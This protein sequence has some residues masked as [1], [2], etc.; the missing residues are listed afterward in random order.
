[1]P[2]TLL[3]NE[4]DKVRLAQGDLK[5]IVKKEGGIFENLTK[6]EK[7]R[8]KIFVES[9]RIR[10][11]LGALTIMTLI[12]FCLVVP[13][14]SI[15]PG[16][17]VNHYSQQAVDAALE[18]GVSDIEAWTASNFTGQVCEPCLPALGDPN[19]K[20]CITNKKCS[21]CKSDTHIVNQADGRDDIFA[22]YSCSTRFA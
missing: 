17:P 7:I 6:T 1:M 19:C 22:C 9:Q 15:E 14:Q 16:C 8:H 12:I 3:L 13:T 10:N 11:L 5:L 2:T 4:V 20:K 18:A 21:E